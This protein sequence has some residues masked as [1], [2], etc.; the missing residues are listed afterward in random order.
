MDNQGIS[1]PI[2][3]AAQAVIPYAE[4]YSQPDAGFG[5]FIS[6]ILGF[7]LLIATLLVLFYLLLGGIEWITSGGDK[8]KTEKARDKMT[9]AIVGLIVLAASVAILTLVQSFLGVS[10]L[11][12]SGGPPSS[13]NLIQGALGRRL[14]TRT[15]Q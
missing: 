5:S 9:Q 1:L 3:E 11:N 15:K 2:G 7:V 6:G 14:E 12:F 4:N 13:G 8:G 10:L